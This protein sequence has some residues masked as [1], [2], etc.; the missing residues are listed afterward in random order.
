MVVKLN[1]IWLV[2]GSNLTSLCSL[3][4]IG[5][6]LARDSLFPPFAASELWVK[7][8]V[9]ADAVMPVTFRFTCSPTLIQTDEIMPDTS[10]LLVHE[11]ILDSETQSGSV[12]PSS[13]WT[14]GSSCSMLKCSTHSRNLPPARRSQ[15]H[16]SSRVHASSL[17]YENFKIA[18]RPPHKVCHQNSDFFDQSHTFP[19]CKEVENSLSSESP[20]GCAISFSGR[21]SP[22]ER[23]ADRI[24]EEWITE[25]DTDICLAIRDSRFIAP[26]TI[27]ENQ[28]QAF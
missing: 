3:A 28:S 16:T 9:A 11:A 23:N 22:A 2:R 25:L 21:A 1:L 12:S 13:H 20:L 26:V 27:A 8:S 7:V 15:Y 17:R 10:C 5:A 14:N 19:A 24:L 6:A 18:V 4:T